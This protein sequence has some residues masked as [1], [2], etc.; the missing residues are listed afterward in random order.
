MVNL[1][2]VDCDHPAMKTNYRIDASG[3]LDKLEA[4]FNQ[5]HVHK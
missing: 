3:V 5:I 1:P 2:L 4:V